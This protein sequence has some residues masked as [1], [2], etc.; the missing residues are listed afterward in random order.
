MT[1]FATIAILSAGCLFSSCDRTTD[2]V[3]QA[4]GAPGPEPLYARLHGQI[5]PVYRDERGD[6]HLNHEII[7]PESLLVKSAPGLLAA[8]SQTTVISGAGSLS[9][10]W[11][12]G[13]IRYRLSADPTVNG[14]AL[15][16]MQDWSTETGLTFVEV[17]NGEADAGASYIHFVSD[18]PDRA[19]SNVGYGRM[20]GRQI[21]YTKAPMLSYMPW[22]L[23]RRIGLALGLNHTEYRS[24]AEQYVRYQND[25]ARNLPARWNW[26]RFGGFHFP[27][28]MTMGSYLRSCDGYTGEYLGQRLWFT[29]LDGST[30]PEG[31]AISSYNRHLVR[32]L[33]PKAPIKKTIPLSG[34]H[35]LVATGIFRYDAIP[36][37]VVVRDWSITIYR[38]QTDRFIPF[39]TA[40]IARPGHWNIPFTPD[41]YRLEVRDV[42]KDRLD[43]VILWGPGYGSP[44]AYA[45]VYTTS[46]NGTFAYL[47]SISSGAD[48]ND[49]SKTFNTQADIDL[50]GKL[51]EVHSL[52]A[53]Q[54]LS[55]DLASAYAVV[56]VDDF[57]EYPLIRRNSALAGVSSPWKFGVY[58][59]N[60]TTR[61]AFG[62][63]GSK[64][65]IYDLTNTTDASGM[66]RMTAP[67][68]PTVVKTLP[69]DVSSWDGPF[70][71]YSQLGR[72]HA[73]FYISKTGQYLRCSFEANPTCIVDQLPEAYALGT[74]TQVP[75][76][77]V[78]DWNL[79]NLTD[80]VATSSKATVIYTANGNGEWIVSK[81]DFPKLLPL[82]PNSAVTSHWRD[83]D[84]NGM[85]DEIRHKGITVV[86]ATSTIK[87]QIPEN[88][89]VLKR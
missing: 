10:R 66:I 88:I 24:D 50:D 63:S 1:R 30:Y 87:V 51:E 82:D 20:G 33:H 74:G 3:P 59:T 25:A 55:N 67:A 69:I 80:L 71:Y 17:T 34:T 78:V 42:N 49:R 7:L 32:A 57:A 72:D 14:A 64:M 36:D 47:A 73:L 54:V 12:D 83:L 61:H 4:G 8:R 89:V 43:E 46:G 86:N 84:N 18:D 31:T 15:A 52:A 60:Y 58:T 21:I 9:A 62:V 6:I 38:W 37:V 35:S 28:I 39:T 27:S 11:P 77:H 5:V 56:V 26:G 13:I 23:K 40:N 44:G 79:D 85:M 68:T 70:L 81:M 16:A 19:C 75:N 53:P 22:T 76:W 65:L 29:R 41:R 45:Q 2:P 48:L